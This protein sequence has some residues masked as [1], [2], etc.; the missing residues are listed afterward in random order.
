MSG[1]RLNPAALP[2][3]LAAGLAATAPARAGRSCEPRP[4]DAT[5]VDSIVRFIKQRDPDMKEIALALD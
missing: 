1:A 2:L 3:C 4:G 5:K